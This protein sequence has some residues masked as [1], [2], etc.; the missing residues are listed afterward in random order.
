[1]AEGDRNRISDLEA[2]WKD[3]RA[4]VHE[5]PA[6]SMDFGLFAFPST[7]RAQTVLEAVSNA[8]MLV[9]TL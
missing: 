3:E 6:F 1:L 4:D 7:L 9:G 2:G 5:T 8:L